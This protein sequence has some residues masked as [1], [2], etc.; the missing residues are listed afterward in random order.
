[1]LNRTVGCSECDRLW[2]EYE[3]A[4]MALLKVVSHHQVATLRQGSAVLNEIGPRL[5]TGT[6]R[7]DAARA[8]I[9]AHERSHCPAT[10]LM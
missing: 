3:A 5:E 6:Q 7:R 9:Q 10:P 8:A 1:M 4:T 2:R